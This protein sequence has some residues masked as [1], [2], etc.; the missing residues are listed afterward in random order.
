MKKLVYLNNLFTVCIGDVVEWKGET[1]RV[2]HIYPYKDMAEIPAGTVF[3]DNVIHG[4][5]ILEGQEGRVNVRPFQIDMTWKDL[6]P[7]VE[8]ETEAESFTEEDSVTYERDNDMIRLKWNGFHDTPWGKKDLDHHF[9]HLKIPPIIQK[10]GGETGAMSTIR[11]LV[12]H[13][14]MEK[15]RTAESMSGNQEENFRNNFRNQFHIAEA[16]ASYTSERMAIHSSVVRCVNVGGVKGI[17]FVNFEGG[18]PVSRGRNQFSYGSDTRD[19][20]PENLEVF[21]I[22]MSLPTLEDMVV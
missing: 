19:A 7:R 12:N 20:S 11:E 6:E 5:I 4:Q 17:Y 8:V 18:E 9:I 2:F 21:F 16:S 22:A 3:D 10:F 14:W 13:L 15:L 1:Y